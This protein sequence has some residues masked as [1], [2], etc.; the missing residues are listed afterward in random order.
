MLHFIFP[1]PHHRTELLCWRE[2]DKPKL[3]GLGRLLGKGFGA[4]TVSAV[5]GSGGFNR[6]GAAS[7]S[8]EFIG[9][10]SVTTSVAVVEG[11]T[12]KAGPSA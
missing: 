1:V 7:G 4:T 6:L 9:V 5:L 11:K 2:S 12:G 3:A 8:D 10:N